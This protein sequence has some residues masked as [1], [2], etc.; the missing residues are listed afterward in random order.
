MLPNL[1]IVDDEKNAQDALEQLLNTEYEV[2]LAKNFD[3]A[4]KL[5]KVEKFD[6]VLTDLRMAGKDGLYVLEEALK[7][8][9]NPICIMMSAYGSVEVAVEAVK[10]GAYDFVT[11]PLDLERLEL[12]MR[13]ALANRKNKKKYRMGVVDQQNV[14]TSHVASTNFTPDMIIGNSRALLSALDEVRTVAPTLAT[15][16]LEG[17]Q[18]QGKSFSRMPYT[19]IAGVRINRLLLYTAPVCRRLCWKVNYLDMK[20][21]LLLELIPEK[22]GFLKKRMVALFF[23]MK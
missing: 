1:L 15:V 23:L 16:L 4:S 2:F 20:K 22:S 14:S 7:R 12:L 21:V 10:R 6:I 8:P 18:A 11:K 17:K 5:L 9:Y 3:D 13:N 19:T